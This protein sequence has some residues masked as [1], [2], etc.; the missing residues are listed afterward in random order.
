MAR[1]RA[2]GR[3]PGAGRDAID[4]D[5]HSHERRTS[6]ST[7]RAGGFRSHARTRPP[8]AVCVVQISRVARLP[9]SDSERGHP[10]RRSP[11]AP[12]RAPCRRRPRGTHIARLASAT[13]GRPWRASPRKPT[14]SSAGLDG[15]GRTRAGRRSPGRASRRG[16]RR[17]RR[18]LVP[19]APAASS[20]ALPST[21][22]VAASRAGTVA[23]E[24]DGQAVRRGQRGADHRQ[25]DRPGADHAS[26]EQRGAR[27]AGRR[28]V[29]NTPESRSWRYRRSRRRSPR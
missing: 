24:R 11:R 15:L 8:D 14:M 22:S 7:A 10:P 21:S 4:V 18:S 28:Q 17:R 16:S 12:W 9:C 26:E 5:Q 13:L 2:S 1:R 19:S 3:S 25:H 20:P 29:A 6:T 23:G 27:A